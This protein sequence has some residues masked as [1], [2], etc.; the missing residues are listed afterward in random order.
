MAASTK[1]NIIV[2]GV[3]VIEV[4]LRSAMAAYSEKTGQKITYQQLA[5]RSGLSKATLEALGSRSDYN[6]TLSTV[7]VLCSCLMCSVGDLL[8]YKQTPSDAVR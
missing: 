2:L 4:K 5:E 6:T 7:D 1:S 3:Q 8:E